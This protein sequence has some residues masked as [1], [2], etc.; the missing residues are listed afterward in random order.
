MY[1]TSSTYV[2]LAQGDFVAT[3]FGGSMGTALRSDTTLLIWGGSSGPANGFALG[4]SSGGD[5]SDGDGLTTAQEINLGTDPFNPDTNGDGINDG[6]AAAA[7][8]SATD[9]DMDGDGVP[10]SVER[11]QGTDPFRTDSDNDETDDGEDCYPL[12]PSRDTCPSPNPSD[13][14]PPTI[15]LDEPTNAVLL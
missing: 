9:P 15:D 12:D 3:D 2:P 5:D 8:Q 4:Y 6:A 10:N 1:H 11:E 14:T 7:G 13:T